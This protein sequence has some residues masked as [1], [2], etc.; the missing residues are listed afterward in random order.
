MMFRFQSS[1][2]ITLAIAALIAFPV[3]GKD[4]QITTLETAHELFHSATN[5][6]M[7][8]EAARQYEYLVKEEGI[9]NGHL[10]YTLGNSWFMAGD[11]GRAIL[12]YRRAEQFLP[13]D[14][15]VQNNLKA[16]LELRTDLIPEKE[17]SPLVARLLGWHLNTSTTFR[18]WLFTAVWL[19]FWGAWFWKE[20]SSK[21]EPRI[22]WVA[23]GLLSALLLAS[24]ITESV[25][26]SRARPGVIIAKEVLARKGDGNRYAPAF[27]DP[28]HAGTEFQG[29]EVRNQWRHIRL[30]DGQTCW[31]PAA[32]GA[33]VALK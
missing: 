11:I 28:L 3:P 29:L 13:H 23:T 8:A 27:L 24:L 2:F 21:K 26:R 14:A 1:G 7:Y 4:Y 6:A 9:H 30:A 15:D 10:F 22:V 16:A 20:R 32:D 18:W 17:P 25:M 12:N 31:I 19:L 5:S 33:P